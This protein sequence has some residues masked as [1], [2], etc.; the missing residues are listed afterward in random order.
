MPS[1]WAA[2]EARLAA[3]ALALGRRRPGDAPGAFEID[4]RLLYRWGCR[5]ANAGPPAACCVAK[6]ASWHCIH[7]D[8][9][10]LGCPP[11]VTV[12]G[13]AVPNVHSSCCSPHSSAASLSVADCDED[14]GQSAD[15]TSPPASPVQPAA[16]AP[17][18][19]A[20]A[21]A[22]GAGDAVDEPD[23]MT[24]SAPPAAD[25]IASAAIAAAP[26]PDAPA[27][28]DSV[29]SLPQRESAS[30]QR[31]PAEQQQPQLPLL[32]QQESSSPEAAQHRRAQKLARL[33][34]APAQSLSATC[35]AA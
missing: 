28:H 13:T 8:L 21:D 32:H 11:S 15:D 2:D 17:A 19:D 7:A 22:G 27:L 23:S 29:N 6:G 10:T 3:L 34:C 20:A 1:G 16:M 35:M 9:P 14:V 25:T 18:S 24:A 26:P 5:L 30:E 4:T 33:K 12:D 31:V